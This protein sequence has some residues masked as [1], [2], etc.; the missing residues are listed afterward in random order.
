MNYTAMTDLELLHYLDLY[1]DDPIVRRLVDLLT[2]TRGGIISDLESAGMDTQNWTFRYEDYKDM[3]PGEYIEQL[4]SDIRYHQEE[5]DEWENKYQRMKEER[6]ELKTRSIMDFIH[7]V[8]L[9]QA[10]SADLVREALKTVNAFKEENA[11]LKEKI[12]MWGRLNQ[13]KQGA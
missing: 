8:Q 1:S 13:V 12:D 7:E 4:R 3:Y 11:S 2:R 9:E 6:N 10:Q 5:A